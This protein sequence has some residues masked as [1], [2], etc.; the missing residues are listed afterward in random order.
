MV[1]TTLSSNTVGVDTNQIM[2]YLPVYFMNT[3]IFEGCT[4]KY[5]IIVPL[6]I[7][8]WKLTRQFTAFLITDSNV[9]S[10]NCY[11]NLPFINLRNFYIDAVT[12][13]V[14]IM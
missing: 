7:F 14:R 10:W 11:L 2:K 12:Y 8:S 1:L 4:K 5:N 3:I 9:I 6:N 13:V